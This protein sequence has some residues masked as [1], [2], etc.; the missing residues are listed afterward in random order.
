MIDQI[1]IERG[2][3]WAMISDESYLH[4]DITQSIHDG[5]FTDSANKEIF[6]SIQNVMR[7]GGNVDMITVI[8]DLSR[9]KR[10]D[11]VGGAVYV[12]GLTSEYISFDQ[13][14]TRVLLLQENYFRS[15]L[16]A[17]STEISTMA[18]NPS[19]DVFE[20]IARTVTLCD[21]VNAV[22]DIRKEQPKK[23]IIEETIKEIEKRTQSGIAGVPSGIYEVDQK[24]GGFER[25]GITIV[26]GRPG[27][28]KTAFAVSA[29]AKMVIE[30]NLRGLFFSL[31]M[32]SKSLY[33]RFFAIVGQLKSSHIWK[34][35]LSQAEWDKVGHAAQT[36]ENC[37]F[38]IYDKYF[39]L[40]E[41]TAKCRAMNLKKPLDFIVIDYMQL[42]HLDDQ[43]KGNREQEVSAIS[44]S[45][46]MMAMQLNV[47]V[48]AL[49]Q[50][51]RAVETRGGDKKPVLSDL[52][53]S[54]SIE[55]DASTVLFTYRP[56]YYGFLVDE[57]GESTLDKAYL[58]MGKHRNGALKDI[59]L[60][61]KH[62]LNQEW[63]SQEQKTVIDFL[64]TSLSAGITPNT[65]F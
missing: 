50:L 51:S 53:E 10:L 33:Q 15:R 49:S 45:L 44:R 2:V 65:D 22:T 61:Y 18:T 8:Q 12:S 52:R 28:G 9:R 40:S 25:G 17:I 32:S 42:I 63:C 38:E 58:I 24:L 62:D 3:L 6:T 4:D 26:A 46:K 29:C 31:E 43:K 34:G 39:S 48:I 35:T 47:P 41:I 19:I 64:Q 59:E 11:Y 56:S 21:E 55:Q 20:A 5:L 57:A 1:K 60:H 36:M 23:T 27:S 16:S 7:S 14:P 37:D 13:Y 54:G 30:Q